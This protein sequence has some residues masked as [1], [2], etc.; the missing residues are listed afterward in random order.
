MRRFGGSGPL[1]C[2]LRTACRLHGT[3]AT[4]T[5]SLGERLVSRARRLNRNESNVDAKGRD[6]KVSLDG[7]LHGSIVP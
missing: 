6:A 2:S 7:D 1:C 5:P 4:G 3:I